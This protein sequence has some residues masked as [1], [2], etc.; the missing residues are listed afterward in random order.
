MRAVRLLKNLLMY[1]KEVRKRYYTAAII[2]TMPGG[3]WSCKIKTKILS[4]LEISGKS[5]KYS[6]N[7]S[8][9]KVNI[10]NSSKDTRTTSFCCL[11]CYIWSYFTSFSS[12]NFIDLE[13]VDVFWLLNIAEFNC[14]RSP[15]PPPQKKKK[16]PRKNFKCLKNRTKFVKQHAE[17]Y[18]G[19]LQTFN[20][21]A[22]VLE[23]LLELVITSDEN[24]SL[25]M[26]IS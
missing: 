25:N 18:P 9:I 14:S 13:Q 2:P 19:L 6:A 5:Q 7:I 23:S 10:V 26:E 12:V 15:T 1:H 17:A 21:F 22:R 20:I 11:Y 3:L 24:S 8:L 4:I 16:T